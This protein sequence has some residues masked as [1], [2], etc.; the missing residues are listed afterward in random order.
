MT[1]ATENRSK[2]FHLHVV[3]VFSSLYKTILNEAVSFAG[4]ECQHVVAT[5]SAAASKKCMFSMR[6]VRLIVSPGSIS[7]FACDAR[8]YK[9]AAKRASDHRVGSQ[10]LNIQNARRN[11]FAAENHILRPD[12]KQQILRQ[13]RKNARIAAGD[14]GA[15]GTGSSVRMFIGGVPINR[16]AKIVA[17]RAYR[18]WGAAACSTL[19]SRMRIT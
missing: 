17:G 14:K 11:S 3:H 4:G 1:M 8:G 10:K 13:C 6:Q 19:P 18:R 5:P 9:L 2:P 7:V 12:T 16:A 15:V